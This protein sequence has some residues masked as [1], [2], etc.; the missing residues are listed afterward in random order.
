M[1]TLTDRESE[2]LKAIIDEYIDSAEAIGSET[3]EKKYPKLGVSP[4]TIRNE[5]VKLAKLGYLRQPH[6]SA[7]RV[8]TPQAM[9][10]YIDQLMKEK[11]MSTAEEVAVKDQIWDYR[12]EMDKLLREAT[13]TLAEKTKTMAVATTDEG[14]IY[15]SGIANILDMPEFYDIEATRAVLSL[16]DEVTQLQEI[17]LRKEGEEDVQVIFGEELGMEPL[18]SCGFI[19]ARFQTG[20]QKRGALG[21][22]GPTRLNYP[23][24]IPVVRYVNDLLI[25]LVRQW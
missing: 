1:P 14:D 21:I 3:V 7:G 24:V 10:F 5:M 4:A 25:D 8:P 20:T 16:I 2:L 15:F 13:H 9:K 12:N 22:V 23:Y 11:Q 19:T 6:T 17:F 18:R